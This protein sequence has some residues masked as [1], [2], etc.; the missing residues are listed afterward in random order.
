MGDLT[1]DKTESGLKRGNTPR[2]VKEFGMEEKV[3]REMGICCWWYLD[4]QISDDLVRVGT[5]YN[6]GLIGSNEPGQAPHSLNL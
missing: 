6:A 5:C 3:K 4:E 2:I 1:I